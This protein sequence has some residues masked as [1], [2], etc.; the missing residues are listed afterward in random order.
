MAEP[1][2][3]GIGDRSACNR[4]IVRHVRLSD[5]NEGTPLGINREEDSGG[6]GLQG[7]PDMQNMKC[8]KCLLDVA[9]VRPKV[10]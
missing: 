10:S 4:M 2:S 9:F 7:G 3:F 5:P 8:L 6:I 1:S